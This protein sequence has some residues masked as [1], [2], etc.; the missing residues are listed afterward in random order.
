VEEVEPRRHWAVV[1]LSC[2]SY[3]SQLLL[4]SMGTWRR[5]LEIGSSILVD[6]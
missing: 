3:C 4:V 2:D 5:A 1:T 6:V